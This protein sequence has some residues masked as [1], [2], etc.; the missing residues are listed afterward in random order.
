MIIFH[1]PAQARITRT[2]GIHIK[3]IGY[4]LFYMVSISPHLGTFIEA[5]F[6]VTN[7]LPDSLLRSCTYVLQRLKFL[8]VLTQYPRRLTKLKLS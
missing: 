4:T 1:H 8:Q 5:C 6:Y 2:E 7:I 3:P